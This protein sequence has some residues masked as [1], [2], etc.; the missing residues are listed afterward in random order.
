LCEIIERERC[1]GAY[2]LGPTA[3]AIAAL[4]A[5]GRHDLSSL[6]VR[7][8][9]VP[10]DAM[11]SPMTSRWSAR[12]GGYGQ[13]EAGGLLTYRALGP[14]PMGSHGWPAPLAPPPGVG[15]DRRAG[16]P[17][18]LGE[19]IARSPSVM[20]GYWNR[21]ELSSERQVGGWHHTHD[22]GRVETDG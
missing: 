3:E 15:P 17:G 18:T 2:I 19:I 11:T 5:D 4:N 12:P 13:T 10:F 7:T 14:A 22:L 1:N 16:G 21:P 6:R 20:V 8:G 9:V